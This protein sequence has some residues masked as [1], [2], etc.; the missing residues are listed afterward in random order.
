MNTKSSVSIY[1]ICTGILAAVFALCAMM[2]LAVGIMEY[3]NIAVSNLETYELRTS[4]SYVATIVRQN[5]A[6]NAI[7]IRNL[8][9]TAVLSITETID[10]ETYENAIYFYDGALRE[11]FH[12]LK[13]PFELSNGFEVLAIADFDFCIDDGILLL[14]A[15]NSGGKKEQMY[16]NL[17]SQ[18]R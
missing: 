8:D 18:T 13:D 1:S 7:G 6:E 16:I 10:D 4:L 2:L 12:E 3:K 14:T 5:D 17:K 11:Y 9:G 15:E